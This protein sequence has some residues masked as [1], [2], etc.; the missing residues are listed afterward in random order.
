MTPEEI[1]EAARICKY[2]NLRIAGL[3]FHLG[4]NFREL[5]PLLIAIEMAIDLVNKIG[6]A[7][8]WHFCPGGGWGAAYHEE[9]L[10]IPDIEDYVRAISETVVKKCEDLRLP[11]PV[12]HLEPG[13][14]LLSRAGVAIYRVGTIK[15]RNNRTWLVIDGGVADNPR[16]AFY[17]SRYTCL[18][19][20]GF[21]REIREEIH[22]AG[23][24]CESGD[25]IIEDLAMQDIEE[26]E[27]I[28]IPGSGAYHLSM[29]S[30]YNG[31]YRPAV[32]WLEKGIAKLIVRRETREDLTRRDLSIT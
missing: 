32:V 4:S 6:L 21:E 28:A 8:P 3:H 20:R 26:G 17:G 14:S 23:P 16:H 27:L 19:V 24:Y 18:P 1:V 31:A 30:N 10:P 15:R 11:L 25:V 2:A 12:L 9:E 22:I 5:A 29:S 7:D 13:R